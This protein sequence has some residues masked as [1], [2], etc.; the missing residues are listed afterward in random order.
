MSPCALSTSCADPELVDLDSVNLDADEWATDISCVTSVLKQ[1]L[2]E[3]PDPV[4]TTQLYDGFLDAAR[5]CL[6][7]TLTARSSHAS[8]GNENERLRH[9]RL[10]ERVNEL[11]DP[12]YAT[13]K[14]FMG[15]LDK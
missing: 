14:Y 15:H 11:P 9:I 10:H 12:N 5:E 13:M 8:T 3:L 2:R 4:L 7:L 6:V 1:W